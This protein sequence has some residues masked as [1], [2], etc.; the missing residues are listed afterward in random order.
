MCVSDGAPKHP[1]G[2]T[3]KSLG[4]KELWD[5][6]K[7]YNAVYLA[8]PGF[9]DELNQLLKKHGIK[10]VSSSKKQQKRVKDLEKVLVNL[11]TA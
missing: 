3:S 6:C 4:V 2:K 9:E 10:R 8:D 1:N 7:K 5:L 11:V